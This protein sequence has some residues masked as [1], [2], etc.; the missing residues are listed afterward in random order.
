MRPAHW[1]SLASADSGGPPTVERTSKSEPIF[2]SKALESMPPPNFLESAISSHGLFCPTSGAQP[3]RS[4]AF[5]RK[6]MTWAPT[7]YKNLAEQESAENAK[8]QQRMLNCARGLEKRGIKLE[9]RSWASSDAELERLLRPNRVGT[10]SNYCRL[11]ERLF[12]YSDSHPNSRDCNLIFNSSFIKGWLEHLIDHKVGRYTPSSSL[13]SIRYFAA[14]LEFPVTGDTLLLR[15]KCSQYKGDREDLMPDNYLR[16]TQRLS[17]RLQE[18]CMA[19]LRE[20]GDMMELQTCPVART[21]NASANKP[22]L[23]GSRVK[24]KRPFVNTLGFNHQIGVPTPSSTSS[25]SDPEVPDDLVLDPE[26]EDAKFVAAKLFILN[27]ST[28]FYHLRDFSESLLNPDKWTPPCRAKSSKDLV[29]L[30]SVAPSVSLVLI[31][32]Y[33]W[34]SLARIFAATLV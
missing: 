24:A 26:A 6:P 21:P 25:E 20:G 18:K 10:A 12:E 7:A 8:C 17:L 16:D 15:N 14:L 13:T 2:K 33:R 4:K 5:A 9:V 22:G 30:E 11:I 31:W 27:A 19:H 28:G 29:T 32:I 3:G 34:Q 23:D 1:A